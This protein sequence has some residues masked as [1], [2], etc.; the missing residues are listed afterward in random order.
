MGSTCLFLPVRVR[1]NVDRAPKEAMDGQI[2]VALKVWTRRQPRPA[3]LSDTNSSTIASIGKGGLG[4]VQH[5]PICS[6]ARMG[7]RNSSI[8]DLAHSLQQVFIPSLGLSESRRYLQALIRPQS[9]LVIH[10][11][12]NLSNVPPNPMIAQ[13]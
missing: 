4:F 10:S 13:V 5:W 7:T 3:C 2:W 12:E 9:S 1:P 8:F 11:A 6:L